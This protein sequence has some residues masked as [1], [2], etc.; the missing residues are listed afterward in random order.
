[1]KKYFYLK[2]KEYLTT[3]N[4]FWSKYDDFGNSTYFHNFG[5]RGNYNGYNTEYIH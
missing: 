3:N 2:N 1:M 5:G 4:L